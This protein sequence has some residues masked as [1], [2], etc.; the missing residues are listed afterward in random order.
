MRPH[1]PLVHPP[2]TASGDKVACDTRGDLR[3]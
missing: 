2:T 3:L 1:K